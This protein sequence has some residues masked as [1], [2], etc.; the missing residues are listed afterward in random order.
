MISVQDIFLGIAGFFLFLWQAK[1]LLWLLIFLLVFP[2]YFIA[3]DKRANAFF[4]QL[5]LLKDDPPSR[6]R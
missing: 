3:G 4:R 2:V 1:L 5:G 6:H